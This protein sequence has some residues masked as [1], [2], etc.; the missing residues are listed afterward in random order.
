MNQ[1]VGQDRHVSRQRPA[2][3][4][5]GSGAVDAVAPRTDELAR[6]DATRQAERATR[7]ARRPIQVSQA[8]KT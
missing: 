7:F 3:N 2:Q 8:T 4:R 5:A 6:P 1:A